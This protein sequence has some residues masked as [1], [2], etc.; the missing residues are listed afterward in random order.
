MTGSH[1]TRAHNETLPVTPD[2]IAGDCI[3]A[4]KGRRRDMP[5][6]RARIP[7]SGKPSM[8]IEYYREVVERIRES[9]TDLV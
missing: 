8:N 3:E 9:D 6:P 4:A 1:T 5:H 2:E 7:E